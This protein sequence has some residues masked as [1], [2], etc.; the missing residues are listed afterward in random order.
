MMMYVTEVFAFAAYHILLVELFIFADAAGC[1][2]LL[3][4]DRILNLI[5]FHPII[6][7]IQWPQPFII[8][9]LH[10]NLSFE[11]IHGWLDHFPVFGSPSYHLMVF[12][13]CLDGPKG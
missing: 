13:L 9:F 11:H 12:R 6:I 10:A 3:Y 1:V 4:D 5:T 2:L 7:Y 8:I